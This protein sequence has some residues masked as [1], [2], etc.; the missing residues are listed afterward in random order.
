VIRQEENQ[1]N[2]TLATDP[3]MRVHET[4][5]SNGLQVSGIESQIAKI[6]RGMASISDRIDRGLEAQQNQSAAVKS[7]LLDMSQ[8]IQVIKV[9][10]AGQRDTNQELGRQINEVISQLD[11]FIKETQVPKVVKRK[12]AARHKPRTVKTPSF[13]LDAIDLWDDETY[14]ATSQAGHVAFLKTGEKQ[15]GWTVTR[16]DRLKGQVKLQDPAGHIHSVT[17]PR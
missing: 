10:I 9:T 12:P 16:I 11:T 7:H 1:A 13:Q 8:D 6:D 14:V 3:D 5:L 15:S 2:A 17:L 4:A